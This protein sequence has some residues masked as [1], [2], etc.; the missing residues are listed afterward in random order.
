M[1]QHYDSVLQTSFYKASLRATK[2]PKEF[3]SE[4]SDNIER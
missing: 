2:L 4:T 1:S 3:R